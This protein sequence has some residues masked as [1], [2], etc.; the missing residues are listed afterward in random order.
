MRASQVDRTEYIPLGIPAGGKDATSIAHAVKR[1]RT[2]KRQSCIGAFIV[3]VLILAIP[4]TY[5]LGD[6][7]LKLNRPLGST[8]STD[9]PEELLLQKYYTGAASIRP[10]NDKVVLIHKTGHAVI[11]DRMS[12]QLI[13]PRPDIPNRLVYSDVALQIGEHQV[14]DALAN[15][16]IDHGR[17]PDF[18][19]Y[20]LL[21]AA[22]ANGLLVPSTHTGWDLD[23]FKFAPMTHH[24]YV[25]YP[26]ATWYITVDGDSFLF[27]STLLRWLERY[28]SAPEFTP[29]Y[30]G[31]DE[32]GDAK[33][34]KYFAHGGA[35]YMMSRGLLQEIHRND[36]DGSKFINDPRFDFIRCGDCAL[37]DY[38]SDLPGRNGHTDAGV[39]L[40]HHDGLDKLIFRPR[41]WHNYV[42]SLHHVTAQDFNALR[43][44]ERNFLPTLP[45]WD[46]VRQCDILWGLAPTVLADG[47]REWMGASKSADASDALTGMKRY[48]VMEDWKAEHVDVLQCQGECL[49][50]QP[51]E[52]MVD[53]CDGACDLH[54]EC[55][56]F[57]FGQDTCYLSLN[58]F[59]FGAPF[60]PKLD[61]NTAW[62]L[63]RIAR[64]EERMPCANPYWRRRADEWGHGLKA[65]KSDQMHQKADGRW[66]WPSAPEG[67]GLMNGT[68]TL[69]GGGKAK[70]GKGAPT[71]PGLK[72]EEELSPNNR[73]R[74]WVK[75]QGPNRDPALL[76][77]VVVSP[78]VNGTRTGESRPTAAA[79]AAAAA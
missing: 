57:L 31:Y 16:S 17:L 2:A 22:K 10:L 14:I 45:E 19:H 72:T 69:G 39:D 59:R 20:R 40:F 34:S 74:P 18:D 11:Y 73:T 7:I 76:A 60:T 4:L 1:R 25:E 33:H 5:Y 32:V 68:S 56:G 67:A 28:F 50:R 78:T 58:G 8:S 54:D 48:V 36:T 77:P 71:L 6:G 63:D 43:S 27:W 70:E 15:F 21:Q 61:V 62:R 64:L 26:D 13:E 42:L 3:L 30:L 9:T 49:E 41:L 44:W 79:A 52:D 23:R 66:R 75:F 38:I 51:A 35:G 53:K 24:A 29:W 55:Y 65:G 37:G 12:I 47:L 46:G